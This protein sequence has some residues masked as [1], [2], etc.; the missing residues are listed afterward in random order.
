MLELA[1]GVFTRENLSKAL[2]YALYEIHGNPMICEAHSFRYEAMQRYF[3]GARDELFAKGLAGYNEA[4]NP[5]YSGSLLE[6]LC[7]SR[8]A[9]DI[10]TVTNPHP[11]MSIFPGDVIAKALLLKKKADTNAKREDN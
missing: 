1:N 10:R 4:G 3:V 11:H 8:Y 6:T 7:V 5:A 2:R 9:V